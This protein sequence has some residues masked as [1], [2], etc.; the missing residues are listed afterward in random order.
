MTT[1]HVECAAAGCAPL[2]VLSSSHGDRLLAS[3][4]VQHPAPWAPT[5]CGDMTE[6]LDYIDMHTCECKHVCTP[7]AYIIYDLSR[8]STKK[9]DQNKNELISNQTN[10]IV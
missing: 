1:I 6:V 8:R 4:L 2:W 10:S 9:K 3:R 7:C 5:H